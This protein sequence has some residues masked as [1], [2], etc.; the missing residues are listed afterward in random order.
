MKKEVGAVISQKIKQLRV[1]HGLTQTEMGKIIGC[2]GARISGYE[3]GKTSVSYNVAKA[4][5]KHFGCLTEYLMNEGIA[6]MD[7]PETLKDSHI[8]SKIPVLKNCALPAT[9][10]NVWE[11]VYHPLLD[12]PASRKAWITKDKNGRSMIVYYMQTQNFREGDHVVVVLEGKT[13]VMGYYYVD[14]NRNICIKSKLKGEK[15]IR[16]IR[17]GLE[18]DDWIEG[19]IEGIYY[20]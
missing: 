6:L 3:S 11:R 20:Q 4:Y 7:E 5:A 2:S 8:V 16:N 13:T 10:N 9:G 12:I 1:K 18:K 15:G 17:V 19:V 14:E